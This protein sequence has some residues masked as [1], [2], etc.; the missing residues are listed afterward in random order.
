MEE[1]E[2]KGLEKTDGNFSKRSELYTLDS[3]EPSRISEDRK[4]LLR[5]MLSDKP[6]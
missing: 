6:A 5:A 4:G 3:G 1:E 2:A